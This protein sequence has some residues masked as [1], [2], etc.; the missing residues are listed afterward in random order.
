M[1]RDVVRGVEGRD[2]ATHDAAA[3]V[4]LRLQH[5]GLPEGVGAG[6]IVNRRNDGAEL[7]QRAM[8]RGAASGVAPLC[9]WGLHHAD[10]Q[11]LKDQAAGS[12][13]ALPR[14]SADEPPGAVPHQQLKQST[15]DAL[16]SLLVH[17]CRVASGCLDQ[18]Q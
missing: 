14:S 11:A 9:S 1:R 6:F 15:H 7:L 13:A 12:A 16:D 2:R 17:P 10:A 3:S 5:V 4:V 8:R 18:P